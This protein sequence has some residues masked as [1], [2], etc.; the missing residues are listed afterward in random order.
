MT[1]DDVSPEA[2]AARIR[3]TLPDLSFGTLAIDD[4]GDD[5]HVL[6]L[7]GRWIVRA[8]R[9][10][11]YRA[12]FGAELSLL[13]ALRPLTAVSVPHYEHVAADGSMGAYR[14]IDGVEMTP[15]IFALMDGDAQAAA[16]AALGQFL[17]VLHGLPEDAIRQGDGTVQRRW[18][19]EQYAARYR[20]M[21]RAKI[22]RVAPPA[23]LA[24]FDAFHDALCEEKAYVA[25]LAHDDL[26]EDH[27]LVAP[28]GTL[29]GVIDFSDAAWG[30][31]SSDFAWFWRLGEAGVD[32]VLAHYARAALDPEL[33][34]RSLWNYV[35]FLINQIAAGD[36][37]KWNLSPAEAVAE[38]EP[39]LERLQ[40]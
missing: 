1:F 20:G 12:R 31:P 35:R 37:A 32:G 28:D 27:I 38:I 33:K 13:A 3:A 5:N 9:T 8:P 21:R 25:G 29:G 11:D 23:A 14:R 10:A 24:R 39:L 26:T 6:V 16:L 40:V 2:W 18:S 4:Y 36:R 17:S 19:G 34:A 7:D 22:A 15:P 30:D